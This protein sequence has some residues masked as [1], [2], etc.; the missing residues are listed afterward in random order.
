MP[1][2]RRSTVSTPAHNTYAPSAANSDHARSTSPTPTTPSANATTSHSS[3]NTAHH[4]NH[5]S[6]TA[7]EA[8][9]PASAGTEPSR[10]RSTGQ[11]ARS[12]SRARTSTRCDSPTPN[13]STAN[14]AQPSNGQSCSPADGKPARSQPTYKPPAPATAQTGTSPA[15]NSAKKD[16]TPTGSCASP[17]A[18]ARAERTRR[19]SPTEKPANPSGTPHLI[20][21]APP[22][23]FRTWTGSIRRES[24]RRPTSKSVW[25]VS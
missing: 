5:A 6:R 15:T 16:K 2:T 12:R 8:K 13:T 23:R 9:S 19:P 24:P 18:W 7:A 21:S 11:N 4:D 1:R 17:N 22:T 25:S 20:R 3:P 10:S 14:K